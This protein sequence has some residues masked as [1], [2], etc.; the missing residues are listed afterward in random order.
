MADVEGVTNTTPAPS[1]DN[2]TT[3]GEAVSNSGL[4]GADISW[5]EGFD[6][7]IEIVGDI[8]IKTR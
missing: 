8:D 6:G 1:T 2:T 7:D 5:F 3:L 4:T